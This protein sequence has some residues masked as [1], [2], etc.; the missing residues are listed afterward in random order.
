MALALEIIKNLSGFSIAKY[1]TWFYYKPDHILFDAG[2]GISVSMRNMIYGIKYVFLTHGHGDH[3]AG[4]PGLLRSRASSMG[5]KAKP[6]HIFYPQRDRNISHLQQYLQD[7]VGRL[8]FDVSWEEL[9]GGE[10]ISLAPN[11]SIEAFPSNHTSST[12]TLGYRILEHR[13]RLKPCYRQLPRAELMALI[14]NQ[15]KQMLSESYDHVLLCFSG[16]SMP[17]P[18]ETVANCEVLLHDAT[19]LSEE[20]RDDDTHAT[21]DEVL[22]VASQANVA[23]LGLF[24]F[25]AR[26]RHQQ[27]MEK[28]QQAV[29]LHK[30]K[31]PVFYIFSHFMPLSF[32]KIN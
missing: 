27:I 16:D 28:I 9:R 6:L 31:I 15:G 14:Q 32:K 29:R 10:R 18:V 8:P 17:L 4:L 20:D 2:E 30:I 26:Y 23:T 22:R 12:I 13:V 1:S 24:H 5:D 11:R 7:S 19:F 25:S 3:I 21:V